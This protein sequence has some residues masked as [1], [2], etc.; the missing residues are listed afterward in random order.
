MQ[1]V[2]FLTVPD[3]LL[4][5]GCGTAPCSQLPGRYKVWNPIPEPATSNDPV[6][7]EQLR[8]WQDRAHGDLRCIHDFFWSQDEDHPFTWRGQ[9]CLCMRITPA[10]RCW[11][12]LHVLMWARPA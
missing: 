10:V 6:I 7:A 1:P 12:L 11:L 3:A 8:K 2:S 5:P 9:C 4:P